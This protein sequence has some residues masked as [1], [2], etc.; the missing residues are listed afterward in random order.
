M[1]TGWVG[2]KIRLVPLDRERHF[3][4]ALRWLNDPEVTQ[5]TLMGDLPLTRLME[6][7]YFGRVS[8][9]NETDVA[10]AIETRD[11]PEEHVGFAGIHQISF[12]HGTGVTG[13]IIGRRGL[14]NRG[15]G[16]DAIAVRTRYAF[17]VLG[18]RMLYSEVLA[19]NVGSLRALQRSG[20]REVGRQ[21]QKYWKRGAYRDVVLLALPRDEWRA[22]PKDAHGRVAPPAG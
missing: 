7:D 10:F 9:P 22:L 17:E 8:R 21:P 12:R 13:T 2:E 1:I 15:L 11:E 5:W 3:E 20:Y 4:N 6:E 18:L 16:T 14:W 19:E